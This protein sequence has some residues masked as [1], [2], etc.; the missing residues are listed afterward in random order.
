MSETL[1]VLLR[2]TGSPGGFCCQVTWELSQ[3]LSKIRE[4]LGGFEMTPT[5]ARYAIANQEGST[6]QLLQDIRLLMVATFE[7]LEA[8]QGVSWQDFWSSGDQG[9]IT[10]SLVAGSKT[11]HLGNVSA[12][13]SYEIEALLS[14]RNSP[15]LVKFTSIA[16]DQIG[17][18]LL[19]V[20]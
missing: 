19:A 11:V 16:I 9:A 18:D 4:F 1:K 15:V 7:P 6:A 13:L 20:R 17:F 5:G 8:P 14:D 2:R 12:V 3:L 10:L